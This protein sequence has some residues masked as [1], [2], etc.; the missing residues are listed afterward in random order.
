[1]VHHW[2]IVL[3]FLLASFRCAV[4]ASPRVRRS[5]LCTSIALST[6]LVFGVVW[7]VPVTDERVYHASPAHFLVGNSQVLLLLAVISV[8]AVDVLRDASPRRQPLRR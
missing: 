3:P 7:R 6:V 4:D 2:I 1:W 8:L 5:I